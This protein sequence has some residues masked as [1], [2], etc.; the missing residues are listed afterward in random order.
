MPNDIKQHFEKFQQDGDKLKQQLPDT[1]NGFG[2]MFAKIMKD[3]EIS[4]KQKELIALAIAVAVQC[5]SCIKLHT[6][7]CIDAGNT[8][9]QIMEAASVAVMMAGGPAW[10]HLPIVMDTIEAIEA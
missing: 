7:K 6:K 8:K 1:V 10:T 4:L 2:T 9:D 3:G 5:E